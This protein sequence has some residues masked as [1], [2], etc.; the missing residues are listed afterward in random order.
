MLTRVLVWRL[1]VVIGWIVPV[2][3]LALIAAPEIVSVGKGSYASEPP[4][5]SGKDA[6]EM[7]RRSFPLV[8]PSLDRAIPTNKYWTHL[9]E[10]KPSGELWTYPL[11]V[12]PKETGLELF[13]PKEWNEK[14]ELKSKSRNDLFR[15][16]GV[17]FQTRSLLVKNWGDWTLSFRLPQT[18][19]RYLDITVGEGL[20]CVWIE[21]KGV[22]L[23]LRPGE[24]A[25]FMDERGGAAVFPFTGNRLVVTASGRTYGLFFTP[26]SQV[27]RDAEGLRLNFSAGARAFLTV[28]AL[29]A[30][31]DLPLFART[32]YSIPRDSRIGWD[33][34][35]DK[36]KVTTTWTVKTEPLVAGSPDTV[37]QGW[38]AHHWRDTKH[39]LKLEGPVYLT[40]RGAMKTSIGNAFSITYDFEGILPFLPPPSKL[41]L[42]NDYDPA[43]MAGLLANCAQ[44]TKYGK[45]TYWGGKDLTRFTQ[46]LQ[47]ARELKDPAYPALLASAKKS[48]ADWL[49]YTPGET[50][51][52]FAK[53]SNWRALIGF[54]GSYG[55]ERFND[56]H[57]HYG[58]FTYAGALL[59]MEDP[60]FLKDYGEMLRLVAKQYANW[61]RADTRFPL[62]RTFDIWAGHSWAG[63]TG[64]PGGNNQESTSEAVQSW[65]G[66]F[67]LGLMMEDPE[68]TS[69]AA[70]GYAM[71]S[72][73]TMEYWF[74]THGDVFSPNY[75]H[76]VI[77]VLWSGGQVY[78][79]Y[80]T[81]DPAW[82]YAIQTLPQCPG[83]DF[84]AR[85]AVHARELYHTMLVARKA[86]EGSDD[87]ARMGDLGSVMLAVAALVDND[88]AVVEF[89]RLWAM[90]SKNV[91]AHDA[92]G[93]TYYQAHAYRKLGRRQFD[94]RMNIPTSSVYY[95]ERT[96][97]ATFAA[98]NPKNQPITVQ[99]SKAGKVIGTFVAAPRKLTTVNRLDPAP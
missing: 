37:L 54:N 61:D 45:D 21:S 86:K 3:P 69:A 64:S 82:I 7:I 47:M 52:Y 50:E 97:L 9:L 1:G 98:Y 58:Y 49:T 71:E 4:P 56:Q 27:T 67:Y 44:K 66:M 41:G 92:S 8:D 28:G 38:L 72:R 93:T 32:A 87:L 48:M 95:N 14:G 24:D 11:R 23:N 94:V 70:M 53:Y 99:V 59:G 30:P 16:E 6:A 26:G 91:T 79:T 36:G 77:G 34:D 22:D 76:P 60:A 42:P 46:Y 17:D 68:M 39:A 2:A 5:D 35:R 80:F 84:L 78:G 33:F 13:F 89:D 75:Q 12:S 31:E 62:F 20:P 10:G 40:P 18:E 63:G 25:V 96:K 29:S 43:R 74:N 85:N 81:G 65:I 55:S 15:I 83:L 57:F 73:A 88:Y 51:H 19:A 90:G